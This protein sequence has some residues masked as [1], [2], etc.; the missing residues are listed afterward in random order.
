MWDKGQGLYRQEGFDRV[1]HC[2]HK[3][4]RFLFPHFIS[5]LWLSNSTKGQVT[6]VVSLRRL[7]T[8]SLHIKT[9]S[10]LRWGI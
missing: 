9:A 1:G 7:D 10:A 5:F 2:K 3:A 8:A 4:E 6:L